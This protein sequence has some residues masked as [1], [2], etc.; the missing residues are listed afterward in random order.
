LDEI[1][2]VLLRV[3]P[4]LDLAYLQTLQLLAL[5]RAAQRRSRTTF[6]NPIEVLLAST[7]K[8][9]VLRIANA[10]PPTVVSREWKRF[11]IFGR[12][13]GRAIAKPLHSSQ[14]TDVQR[15]E[16]RTRRGREEARRVLEALSVGFRHPVMLQQD[17]TGSD[18]ELRLWL[19]DGAPLAIARKA[20]LRGSREEI[21]LCRTRLTAPQK[22]TVSILG[23]HLRS[24]GIRLA[25]VDMIGGQVIDLN[26]ASPGML[27]ELE[28]L[29]DSDLAGRIVRA[30]SA[31]P[32]VRTK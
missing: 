20:F 15:L 27:I 12:R 23:R 17:L 14:S 16:W 7:S 30:L 28:A 1:E 11:D 9:E 6:I 22:N 24:R 10:C 19:L 26:Y 5:G 29:T 31:R 32:A 2:A 8:L 25:A 21:G 13:Q 18:D 3:D 4:P